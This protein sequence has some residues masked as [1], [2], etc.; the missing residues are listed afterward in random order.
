M[1]KKEHSSYYPIVKGSIAAAVAG[2]RREKRTKKY[3]NL[4]IPWSRVQVQPLWQVAE[5]RKIVK[6]NGATNFS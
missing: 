3:T 1:V 2:S 5:Q 4:S 6:T